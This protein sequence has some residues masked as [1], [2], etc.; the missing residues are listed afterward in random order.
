MEEEF[1]HCADCVDVDVCC[2]NEQCI[3]KKV[4]TEDV[5]KERGEDDE[6]R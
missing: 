3:I 2:S 5:A 1:Q 6:L 4:I